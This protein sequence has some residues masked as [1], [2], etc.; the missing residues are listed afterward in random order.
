MTVV[1]LAVKNVLNFRKIYVCAYM[2]ILHIY[3]LL[4]WLRKHVTMSSRE[5]AKA[6]PLIK[7]KIA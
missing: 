4:L 5:A 2:C 6:I 7:Q 3:K 1:L